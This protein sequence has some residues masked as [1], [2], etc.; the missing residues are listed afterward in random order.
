MSTFIL[1]EGK[2][3]TLTKML[4]MYCH[5]ILTNFIET[6]SEE[7]AK[8]VPYLICPLFSK[9]VKMVSTNQS[10]KKQNEEQVAKRQTK[11]ACIVGLF[12]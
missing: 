12:L 1:E 5:N 9:T 2:E 11:Y 7:C 10:K 6:L 4:F 3:V 8:T